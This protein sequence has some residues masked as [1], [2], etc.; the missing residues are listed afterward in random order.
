MVKSLET[1]LKAES[2]KVYD[3]LCN[4]TVKEERKT[5]SMI[6][7]RDTANLDA[8][9]VTRAVVET[10]AENTSDEAIAPMLHLAV[11]DPVLGLAY[12]AIYTMDSMIG[13]KNDR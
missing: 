4:R 7:G 11:G 2:M 8:T 1:C 9:G 3:R 13:Y 5:V 6:I 10:V 12:K